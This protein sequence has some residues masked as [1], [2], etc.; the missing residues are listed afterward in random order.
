MTDL[1][2]TI[3]YCSGNPPPPPPHTHTY[4]V[5]KDSHFKIIFLSLLRGE[6]CLACRPLRHSDTFIKLATCKIN[7][8]I[9][10]VINKICEYSLS[11]L[12]SLH[13]YAATQLVKYKIYILRCD[14]SVT[15]SLNQ[16]FE[17]CTPTESA[18]TIT[19]IV[20]NL[21]DVQWASFPSCTQRTEFSIHH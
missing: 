14:V 17:K 7:I 8:H 1:I 3:K 4:A 16:H 15:S 19:S 11:L 5:K 20:N 18:Y 9:T 21:P 10:F 13:E 6:S 2:I 12:Q